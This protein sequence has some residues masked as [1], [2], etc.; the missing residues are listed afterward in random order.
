M[1]RENQIL[2]QELLIR[3]KKGDESALNLLYDLYLVVW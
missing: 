1:A 2:K 3:L